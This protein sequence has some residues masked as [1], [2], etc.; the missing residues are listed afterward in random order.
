M[1]ND[2]QPINYE[3]VLADLEA[4]KAKLESAIESIRQILGQ[5]ANSPSGSPGGGISPTGKPAHDAFIG[6]S[7]PEAAKKHLTA[8]RRKLPTQELMNALTDG[9]L[10]ESKY[11]TVYAILRRRER[12][13]G[14]IINMKGDWALSEWY[15][16]YRKKT[17]AEGQETD[18]ESGT[19]AEEQEVSDNAEDIKAQAS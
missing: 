14:D 19:E 7:I 15:P 9:G 10:P 16:N 11:S 3:A 1:G 5:T 13:V 8:V 18:A 2:I 6:M 12:Q 4:R 17:K